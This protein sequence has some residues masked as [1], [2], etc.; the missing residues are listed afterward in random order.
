MGIDIVS[1]QILIESPK[2][3]TD[4]QFCEVIESMIQES[5]GHR[6]DWLQF[7]AGVRF[8]RGGI[9][10][11][12]FVCF[13]GSVGG[14]LELRAARGDGFSRALIYRAENDGIPRAYEIRDVVKTEF[15]PDELQVA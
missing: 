4:E 10:F 7:S 3:E 2:T 1:T 8:V 5:Y 15:C 13:A 6:P 14:I 11:R 12:E 9:C